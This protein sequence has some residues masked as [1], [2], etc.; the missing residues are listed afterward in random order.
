MIRFIF[1][2]FFIFILI[3]YRGIELKFIIQNIL[4]LLLFKLC[5]VISFSLELN[6]LC[7]NILIGIDWISFI[8]NLILV[9]IIISI[10]MVR[11]SIYNNN[12][13]RKKFSIVILI[14]LVILFLTFSVINFLVFYIFFERRLVPVL[15]IIFKWGKYY[16]RQ[17]AGKYL[18]IYTLFASFPFLLIL[19]NIYIDNGTLIIINFLVNDKR[20]DLFIYILILIIFLVK[21]PIIFFHIWLPK[22]HVEA[23]VSGSLILAG[24]IL[25]LGGY[26]IFRIIKLMKGLS[27]NLRE[28]LVCYRYIGGL[29]VCMVRIIQIDLKSLVA[30]RSVVHIAVIIRGIYTIRFNGEV[31][32][33]FIIVGHGVCSSSLFYIG[34]YY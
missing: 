25:K 18:L 12:I 21:L 28:N 13:Y 5:R 14:L 4:I 9:L 32:G 20:I 2:I 27:Y 29:I 30:Y 8:L 26:G 10:V 33:I 1:I 6:N 16:D 23:P 24:V 34:K 19:I 11:N 31:G 3:R 22:A 7:I 15:L 17:E